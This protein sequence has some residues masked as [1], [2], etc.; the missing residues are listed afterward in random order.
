ME[1][2]RTI[3]TPAAPSA[4]FEYLADFRSTTEWDPGTVDTQLIHGDGGVGSEYRNLSRF[5]GRET[6]LIYVVEE[7]RAD[8]RIVLRGQNDTVRVRDTM[9]I[10]SAAGGGSEVSYRAEFTFSG[11][12]RLLTPILWVAL[13]RLVDSAAHDLGGVL[14]T[15]RS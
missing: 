11:T 3:A 9:T 12:A 13:R 5:L 4:V 14:A 7:L 15:L 10:T 2:V 6:E 1:F 8:S